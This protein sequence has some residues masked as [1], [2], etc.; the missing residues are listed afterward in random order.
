MISRE[1]LQNLSDGELE[2][3]LR[4]ERAHGPAHDNLK[5]LLLLL[6]PDILPFRMWGGFESL[7]RG[8]AQF[9]EWAADDKAVNGDSRRAVWLAGA[10]VRVARLGALTEASPLMTSLVADGRDLEARV[11]RLLGAALDSANPGRARPRM[12]A[13][14]VL[15][16]GF[17]L[18]AMSGPATLQ[19]AHRLLEH[20]IRYE[21]VC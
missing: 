18:V 1:V 19:T 2:A 5:R 6:A 20:L 12:L 9:A 4:H 3:A 15:L 11:N 10:L 13:A 17:L 21:A 14:I 8:W 7:E 16:T